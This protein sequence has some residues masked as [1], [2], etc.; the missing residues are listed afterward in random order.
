MIGK[1]R[2]GH[3]ERPQKLRIVLNLVLEVVSVREHL[4]GISLSCLVEAGASRHKGLKVGFHLRL[5]LVELDELTEHVS[6]VRPLGWLLGQGA[7]E[8]A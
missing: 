3:S 5:P 2:R 4:L 1:N 7:V 8:G 6:R